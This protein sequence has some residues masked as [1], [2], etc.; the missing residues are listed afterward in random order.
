MSSPENPGHGE[1]IPEYSYVEEP[2]PEPTPL[3]EPNAEE[4]S[5]E[6]P[7]PKEQSPEK[8]APSASYGKLSTKLSKWCEA[9][10]LGANKGYGVVA[11]QD[12]QAGE[13]ILEE[14]ALIGIDNHSTISR[15]AQAD[16]KRQY[17]ALPE[18]KRQ[19]FDRLHCYISDTQRAANEKKMK[20]IIDDWDL[21]EKYRRDYERAQTFATNCFDVGTSVTQ[22]A[23]FLKASR[24]NHSCLPTC[25][26]DVRLPYVG[27]GDVTKS[28]WHAYAVRDIEK[29]EELTISYN[30]RNELREARQRQLRDI[31]GFTCACEV[32][33]LSEANKARA[34]AHEAH[35]RNLASDNVW[36]GRNIYVK[37]KWEA[38]EV[39]ARLERLEQRIELCRAVQ[40]DGL[41]WNT[42]TRAAKFAAAL[43]L[44]TKDESCLERWKSYMNEARYG[45]C[46]RAMDPEENSAWDAEAVEDLE[47]GEPDKDDIYTE[48]EG[49]SDDDD[50][51]GEDDTAFDYDYA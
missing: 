34:D 46:H 11:L 19:A 15:A 25:D 37:R 51:D 42:L 16:I 18:K 5:P 47:K 14:E 17:E 30:V 28:R 33:D 27:G 49:G 8:K 22:A 44:R 40:D 26:F 21:R 41:L 7:S 32:C 6:E 20:E 23:L 10:F 3:K 4:P 35:L 13:I 9:Q 29:G 39:V 43:W 45:L 1:L 36:W 31:W 12:I 50:D 48:S 38:D 2:V 24:F